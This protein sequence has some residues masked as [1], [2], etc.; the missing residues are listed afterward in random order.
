MQVNVQIIN[1]DV[2]VAEHVVMNSDDSAT[3]LLNARLTH[4]RQHKAYL[5]AMEHLKENDFEKH[6]VDEIEF[7]AHNVKGET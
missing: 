6:D 7:D 1:M 4:E 2:Q 3:I 5:H